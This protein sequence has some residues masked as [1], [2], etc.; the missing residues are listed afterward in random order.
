MADHREDSKRLAKNTGFMLLR[1][2]I[3][4]SVGLYSSRVVLDVLGE[5]DFGIYNVVGTVVVLMAFLRISLMVASNRFISYGLG[6]GDMAELNRTFSM[7]LNAHA[8]LAGLLFVILEAVGPWFIA[9]HLNIPPDR[10]GAAQT[11][12]QFS[13]LT[14]CLDII[15]APFNSAI[16]AHERLNFYT[17]TSLVDVGLK[18]A[19][20]LVL[21]YV[22]FDKLILY[23]IMMCG[24]SVVMLLWYMSFCRRHFQETRYRFLWDG[25]LL[26]K[27]LGYTGWSLLVNAADVGVVESI[28][29]FINWFGGVVANA[30]AGIANQVNSQLLGV[31]GSFTQSYQPQI[32][33]A[34]AR[35][36]MAYFNQLLFSMS[37]LSFL[38]LFAVNFPVAVYISWI[39]DLWLVDPPALSHIFILPIMAFSLID[40]M[41]MPL[42][43][44]VHA[45]GRI[46]THQI[47]MA[48]IKIL[49]IPL[50]YLM[51]RFGAPLVTAYAV[52]ATMNLVCCIVR[53][54]YMGHHIQLQVWKYFKEVFG[55]IFAVLVLAVPLPLWYYFNSVA[56]GVPA[57][58]SAGPFLA[59]FLILYAGVVYFVGLR[60]NE[61]ER[62]R[63]LLHIEKKRNPAE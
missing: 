63:D 44:A 26:K 24:V 20:I 54:L 23:G 47:L 6:V 35:E 19:L 25:K 48:S 34:Y 61:K 38:L 52:W 29:I 10:M 17:L 53:I 31:L 59:M 45:T 7:C 1:L 33:K 49:N 28:N 13:L 37:K 22:L 41:S 15:R 21:R 2:L 39:L 60:S 50:I 5:S 55:S 32:I 62:V 58:K 9:N 57:W 4:A 30:A 8:I 43:N 51:L 18:L 14:V 46:R 40:A 11:V 3:V 36:D 27:L 12:F 16:I 42:I 56:R